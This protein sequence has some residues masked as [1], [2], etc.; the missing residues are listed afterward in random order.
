MAQAANLLQ[1][2]GVQGY[3]HLHLPIP[4]GPNF[5]E[6]YAKVGGGLLPEVRRDR[7][8]PWGPDFALA[9]RESRPFRP[10][11]PTAKWQSRPFHPDFC[12]A[13]RQSRPFRP[14]FSTAKRQSRPFC[15]TFARRSGKADLPARTSARRSAKADLFTRLWAA[16]PGLWGQKRRAS[17]YS[18]RVQIL[19]NGDKRRLFRRH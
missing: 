1:N 4:R 16:R 15:R 19:R 9:K 14:D 7:I 11:F 12:A 8:A 17:L 3:S 10:D 5:A 18:A 6:I 2:A 13:K